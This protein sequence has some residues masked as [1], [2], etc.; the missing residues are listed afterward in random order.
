MNDMCIADIGA[1]CIWSKSV[2]LQKIFAVR[3]IQTGQFEKDGA[4]EAA[5]MALLW[6]AKQKHL[7]A[8]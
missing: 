7:S 1:A 5:I 4:G 3:A 8:R 6:R 2:H